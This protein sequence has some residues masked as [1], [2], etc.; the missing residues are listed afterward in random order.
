MLELALGAHLATRY[1]D[2]TFGSL[3]T[4][5]EKAIA[6]GD[7]EDF[8]VNAGDVPHNRAKLRQLLVLVRNDVSHGT[9]MVMMPG[10]ALDIIVTRARMIDHVYGC[11]QPATPAAWK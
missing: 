7:F 3:N 4:C 2:K 11:P 10:Q 9:D 8:H 5:L 1:P 6:D